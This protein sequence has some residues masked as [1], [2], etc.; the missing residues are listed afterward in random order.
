MPSVT[1]H[2]FHGTNQQSPEPGNEFQGS[3]TPE[4]RLIQN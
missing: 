1:Q 2:N 4:P 3:R